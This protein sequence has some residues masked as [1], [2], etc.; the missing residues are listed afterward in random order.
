MPDRLLSADLPR[1]APRRTPTALC[2]HGA[3]LGGRWPSA[4]APAI[5]RESRIILATSAFFDTNHRDPSRAGSTRPAF[6]CTAKRGVRA[7]PHADSAIPELGPLGNRVA[8]GD[9]KV[10]KGGDARVLRKAAL[11]DFV[12]DRAR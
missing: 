3:Y 7:L 6:P 5:L 1:G 11:G 4:S 2:T 8:L 12:W 10:Q 9:D